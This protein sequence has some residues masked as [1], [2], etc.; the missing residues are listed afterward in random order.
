MLPY[1]VTYTAARYISMQSFIANKTY[2]YTRTCSYRQSYSRFATDPRSVRTG[3]TN[4]THAWWGFF[5]AEVLLLNIWTRTRFLVS[6]TSTISRIFFSWKFNLISSN[7]KT[8]HY[9]TFRYFVPWPKK[10]FKKRNSECEVPSQ[11][12]NWLL[13]HPMKFGYDRHKDR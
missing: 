9:S 1:P 8:G 12:L 3:T 7:S 2:M 10:C 4:M 13:R 11:D 5:W 6:V